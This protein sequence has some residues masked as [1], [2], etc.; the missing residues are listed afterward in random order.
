[1]IQFRLK[2]FVSLM[3]HQL[4]LTEKN[5]YIW[6]MFIRHQEERIKT[7]MLFIYSYLQIF[8][9]KKIFGTGKRLFSVTS[10]KVLFSFVYCAKQEPYSVF[11]VL[12]H[13]IVKCFYVN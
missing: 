13:I 7:R 2:L 5:K 8:Y 9:L 4:Q 6:I 3:F 1:V 10:L 11:Q 12:Q